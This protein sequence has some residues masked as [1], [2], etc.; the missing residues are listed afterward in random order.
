MEEYK[1]ENEL[2]RTQLEALSEE[3]ELFNKMSDTAP[4]K[5]FKGE[6]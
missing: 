3:K 6:S 2:L 4:G 5:G 1:S